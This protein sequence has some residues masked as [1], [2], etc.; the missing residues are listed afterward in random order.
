M[1]N[2]DLIFKTADFFVLI[3]TGHSICRCINFTV[4]RVIYHRFSSQI[5]A[6]QRY[7]KQYEWLIARKSTHCYNEDG[8]QWTN[9]WIWWIWWFFNPSELS[10]HK[11]AAK[12]VFLGNSGYNPFVS[13]QCC[14]MK[15]ETEQ[16]GRPI[17]KSFFRDLAARHLIDAFRPPIRG[18]LQN[19]EGLC[20]CSF[21]FIVQTSMS[22]QLS[23]LS[24]C[25]ST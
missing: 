14:S 4:A 9:D 1:L 16:A 7:L 23:W 17:L 11:V 5:S 22:S 6:I 3:D 2:L 8:V 20:K 25:F 24:S 19:R 18:L 15:P 21:I 12:E 13:A 10:S